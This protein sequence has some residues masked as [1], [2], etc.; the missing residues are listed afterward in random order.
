VNFTFAEKT[1]SQD[2]SPVQ[3]ISWSITGWRRDT[4]LGAT[5][6]GAIG[7]YSG[8]VGFFPVDRLAAHVIKTEQ[9]LQI[10]EALLPLV[11]DA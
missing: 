9:D 11:H 6:R 2:L 8:R 4:Y 1:N 10:A 3:R 7:T 5:G